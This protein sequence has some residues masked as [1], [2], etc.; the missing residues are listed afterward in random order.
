MTVDYYKVLCRMVD[1]GLTTVEEVRMVVK[2]IKA[3]SQ[4]Q[5]LSEAK[6]L[7]DLLNQAIINNGWIPFMVNDSTIT[8]MDELL[9]VDG[10]DSALVERVIDW[11]IHDDFWSMNVL[12]PAKLRKHFQVLVAK[13]ETASKASKLESAPRVPSPVFDLVDRMR[14]E[15][16]PK[17][18][19]LDLLAALRSTPSV[20]PGVE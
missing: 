15:A 4:S 13:A 19:N 14:A 7:C 3:E 16:V 8:A 18:A 1:L 20:E 9:S 12:N 17:P 5:D 6:R 2:E 10:H 11:A